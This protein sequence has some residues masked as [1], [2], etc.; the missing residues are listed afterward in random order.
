MQ[1][2][3]CSKLI[4]ITSVFY[5]N[6]NSYPAL[7]VI[8]GINSTSDPVQSGSF[9]IECVVTGLPVPR[10]MWLK[11]E[12]VVNETDTFHRIITLKFPDKEASRIEVTIA[13]SNYNGEYTCV[14]SNDAGS[15][16]TSIQ[17]TL[18]GESL[19]A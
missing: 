18:R 9:F 8:I 2:E 19:H 10:V 1:F 6:F 7:P 12:A 17:I 13:T 3:F 11:D 5:I 15:T 4:V 14:A 16:S